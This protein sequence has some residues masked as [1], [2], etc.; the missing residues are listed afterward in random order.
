MR[1]IPAALSEA[2]R[3]LRP[4]G[5][6]VTTCDSFR[7]SA[8][9]DEMELE[10]FDR[11]PAVLLGVNEQVPRFSDFTSLL[12]QH[13]GLLEV[14]LYTHT[15]H[16]PSFPKPLT[17]LTRWNL[18]EDASRLA[19][20][21]GSLAMRVRL[22][23]RW[24]AAPRMQAKTVLEP[25]RYAAWIDSGTSAVAKLAPLMPDRYVD[26]PFPG[27]R[28]TKFELLNG[29]RLAV[30]GKASRTAY[31]RGRW[32]LRRPLGVD[33]LSFE[34]GLAAGDPPVEDTVEILLDGRPCAER[35]V[36]SGSF[37]SVTVDLSG[38]P[39]GQVFVVEMRRRHAGDSLENG[40]FEV[41]DRHYGFAPRPGPAGSP[42]PGP[43]VFAVIPV[44]NRLRFTRACIER[45]KG[46][47]HRPLR[48]VVSDGGSA[49]GTVEAIRAE[50]PDVVVLTSPEE[51]WWT[52]AMAAGIDFALR[53][54]TDADDC[55]LMMNNDTQVPPDYVATLLRAAREKGAAVGALIVDSRD[56]ARVLDAGEY[57]DWATYAF[58]VRDHVDP[59]ERLREDVDVLPGRGS[60]VPLR[61]IRA[62]GNVDAELLPHYLADYEFFTRLK[63]HG[64]ALAVCY[65][66]RLLAHI[67][68][69]GIVPGVRRGS[70]REIWNERFSRRSMSNVVDHWRFVSRHAPPGR[71]LPIHLR[72]AWGVFADLALRTP[73]R[74]LFLPLFWLIA[75][76]RRLLDVVP[77]QRRVFAQFAKDR[78]RYGA[79]VLCR[80][81]RIPRV[82][83]GLVYLVACPGPVSRE[84]CARLALPVDDL[85]AAGVLREI[86]GG[87]W[88]AFETTGSAGPGD[89]R[90][91]E[92]LLRRARSPWRKLTRPLTWQKQSPEGA[93]A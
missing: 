63:R 7:P 74:P 16:G 25:A 86:G 26:L 6:L 33:H 40:A 69:T 48:I 19:R 53:E 51:L 72:L 49:D 56:P 75:V 13:A 1:D 28:G 91:R 65:E 71:G 31:R 17:T 24:P 39:A 90:S 81:E 43:T 73:V 22:N 62:A 64:F 47:T 68:E 2:L 92:T 8:A 35:A 60:L 66:T 21:G 45:L 37:A 54:S 58:P 57:V 14:A 46:Q 83:R 50:H 89:P 85:L 36:A 84:E 59:G 38:V 87:E 78:A 34:V 12:R 44:F 76:P 10:I 20:C 4:G 61:M 23:D 77:G 9:G 30:P 52:G 41:R 42:A 67:E 93:R 27:P 80:P 15:L 55:V 18:E 32:F 82:I 70:F 3:V 88:L 79:D 11:E 29:W 5:V